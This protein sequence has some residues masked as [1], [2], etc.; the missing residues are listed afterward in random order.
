M[1]YENLLK[2]NLGIYIADPQIPNKLLCSIST[3][4]HQHEVF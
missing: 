4:I 2:T 1:D 3:S